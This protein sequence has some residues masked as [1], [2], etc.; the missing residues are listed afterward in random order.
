M[1]SGPDNTPAAVKYAYLRSDGTA[2]IVAGSLV[3]GVG[4]YAYQL[5]GGRTLGAEAFAPV[6]VLLTIHFLTFIVLLLPIEQLVV[7]RLTINRSNTGL[8]WKAWVLGS[9]T[10]AGATLFAELGVD[11]YLNGDRRFI[12]FTGATVAAHFLFAS[13]RGHLAGWRRFRGYGMSSGAASLVRLAVAVAVTI[14][15]PSA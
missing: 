7:R 10:V 5:L 2:Y 1:A 8:P 6:S 14:V 12:V 15:H 4:A 11:R 13:A 3:A 9:L